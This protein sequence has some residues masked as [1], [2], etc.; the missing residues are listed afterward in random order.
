MSGW[1]DVTD[2]EISD[3]ALST[4]TAT[5]TNFALDFLASTEKADTM[6]GNDVKKKAYSVSTC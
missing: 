1:D 6:S 3:N 4:F 2:N 5:E